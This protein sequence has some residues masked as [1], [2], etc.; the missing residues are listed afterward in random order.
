MRARTLLTAAALLASAACS[1]LPRPAAVPSPVITQGDA[2]RLSV[3]TPS[4][5]LGATTSATFFSVDRDAYAAAFAVTRD[6]RLRVVW[7]DSPKEDGLVRGGKTYSANASFAQYGSWVG[8]PRS[9]VPYVFVITSDQRLDL[10][11]FGTGSRWAYQVNLEDVGAQA[12]DAVA[13]VASVVLPAAEASYAADYAY[14]GPRV[15]GQAQLLALNCSIRNVNTARSFSYYRDLWAVFDPWDSYLGPPAFASAWL[16]SGA[17]FP[18]SGRGLTGYYLDRMSR[19]SAAFY[20]GCPGQYRGSFYQTLVAFGPTVVGQPAAPGQPVD[21]TAKP[22]DS[23]KVKPSEIFAGPGAQ[24]AAG[25]SAEE[26]RARMRERLQG[27]REE[28]RRDG[29]SV[30]EQRAAFRAERLERLSHVD[31]AA[32]ERRVR[33]AELA[34][35][36]RAE[37]FD[38]RSGRAV[39][40]DPGFGREPVGPSASGRRSGRSSDDGWAGRTGT[41]TAGRSAGVDRSTAASDRGASR[42]EGG[43]GRSG[44]GGGSRGGGESR[45][46]GGGEGRSRTP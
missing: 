42:G 38:R 28:R 43:G 31:V 13:S 46:S 16:W 9:A 25:A 19:A 12:E 15:T 18:F 8:G 4:A 26:R 27:E 11:R 3:W 41:S 21:T 2:P 39:W 32:M 24:V 6:G 29:V 45:G 34:E 17:W 33:A 10:S 22:G 1:S 7:P 36:G 40:D 30:S 37:A 14:I 5:A 44:E 20:G 23:L 35:S